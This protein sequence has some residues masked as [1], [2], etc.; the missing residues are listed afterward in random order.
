MRPFINEVLQ[1]AGSKEL[2]WSMTIALVFRL[3]MVWA[4]VV[5]NSI[6]WWVLFAVMSFLIQ[7][8]FW[9]FHNRHK[10]RP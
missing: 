2:W 3:I 6:F 1:T 8:P 4:G 10:R 5:E 9:I 7:L